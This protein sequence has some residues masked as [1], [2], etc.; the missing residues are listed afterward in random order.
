M[1]R[2]IFVGIYALLSFFLILACRTVHKS[3]SKYKYHLFRLILAGFLAAFF[4]TLFL[5]TPIRKTFNAYASLSLYYAST[6]W[7]CL[8]LASFVF[9]YTDS[10]KFSKVTHIIIGIVATLDTISLIINSFTHHVF[11]LEKRVYE[12]LNM[13][14]MATKYTFVE[15]IHLGFVY[16]LVAISFIYLIK[17]VISS[18][19]IY[20]S[21]YWSILALVLGVVV[22]NYI[23]ISIN[24]PIDYSVLVYPIMS[25]MICHFT[26]YSSPNK[27]IRKVH[28]LVVDEM[29]KPIFCF[30]LENKC[31]YINNKAV[32]LFDVFDDTRLA[33]IEAHF[34]S[35]IAND[36][37]KS[38]YAIWSSEEKLNGEK[39][40]FEIEYFAIRDKRK[41]YVGCFFTMD[42]RTEEV[43]KFQEEKYRATHDSLTDL[44]TREA[45]FEE[46]R[47]VL[48]DDPATPRYIIAS[49]IKDFK[50]I[51]E[52]FGVKFGDAILRK[53]G[54]LLKKNSHIRSVVG[55]ISGDRF[56]VLVERA[57]FSEVNLLRNIGSMCELTKESIFRMQIYV[58]VYAVDDVEEPVE[59]MLDKAY[60]AINRISG[61]YQKNIA[62]YDEEDIRKL[63][64]EKN[65]VA[66]FNRAIESKEFCIYLQPQVDK[67]GKLRGAESLVRW[68]HTTRGLI[69]PGDFI[70]VLEKTGLISRLD[71]YIWEETAER[72]KRWNDNGLG[73]FYISVNISAKDFYYM[74]IYQTLV[75]IVEMNGLDPKQLKLEITETVI[76][77]D[78]INQL[79]VVD[80]LRDYG[81]EI[82]IDDFGSGFSSLNTLKDINVDV[83]KL[84][85]KFIN[86]SDN[87]EKSKI[88]VNS[89]VGMAKALGLP[90]I[91]EGVETKEQYDYLV[92]IGCDL[93]QGYYFS[94]PVPVQEF[95]RDYFV[96]CL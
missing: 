14:Y 40:Y 64:I 82:E 77:S 86:K 22:V 55:R 65:I 84:D 42:D 71:K 3:N 18:P 90:I 66:D 13:E 96:Q 72:L 68:N 2:A 92:G 34:N 51:N 88:I 23:C 49:N 52:L 24:Y 12:P 75:D 95:E 69:Y 11:S 19:A 61:D 36:T 83:L 35:W 54:E 6:D 16:F 81:F 67:D 37:V 93:F 91:V 58:G 38:D 48:R 20:K 8:V 7:L 5:M 45:F 9:F 44:L 56:A 53:Q 39:R 29:T 32:E 17:K 79:A 89:V 60:M 30:D 73:K 76:M 63:I 94:K 87:L 78:T 26:L 4:Y 50:L 15:Y 85:M 33:Q 62:Y 41:K 46:C 43:K 59:I 74:D 80:K 27:L 57:F 28:T 21:R 47:K 25:V 70:G 31:V 10:K 1:V